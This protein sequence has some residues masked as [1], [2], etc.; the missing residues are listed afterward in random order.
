MAALAFADVP[1]NTDDTKSVSDA[2]DVQKDFTVVMAYQKFN[3]N[4]HIASYSSDAQILES[5]YEGVFSYDPKTL[6]PVPALAEKY[7]ISRDKLRWTLTIRDNA[8]FSTGEKITAAR[9]RQSWLELLKTPGAPYAS[10]L[11]CVKN[12]SEFR[13]G[14]CKDADVGL[15]ARNDKTLVINLVAPT[16][17]LARLLCHHA[18]AVTGQKPNSFSGAYTLTVQEEEKLVL[19][20]NKNYWDAK[21]VHIPTITILCSSEI[22]ENSWKFNTGAADWISTMVDAK[23]VLNKNSIH[24]SAVFGTEYIF[25]SCNKGPCTDVDFRNA[26]VAAVPWDKLRAGILIPAT[27]FIYP[28][29]G[30]PFV[31]GLSDTSLD[32]A[33][34]MMDAARAK[35]K[36][37][38]GQKIQLTFGISSSSDRQKMFVET[39]KAA[40]APLGVELS[41]SVTT[42]ERYISSIPSWDADLFTYSWIG[43]FADP[44]AFLELFRDGSTLNVSKWKNEKYTDLLNKAAEETDGQIHYKLLS[45]AE[46]LL[47]DEGEVL[48]V[49]HSVSLHAINLGLVGGWYANPLDIHP[50]KYLYFKK[51]PP[52]PVYNVVLAK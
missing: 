32:D 3:L 36:I 21:N 25:F 12:A 42:D 19:A 2:A 6:E 28:L 22:E 13:N 34:E 41:P 37:P 17:H 48:P 14:K 35:L 23:L 29:N 52:L 15:V 4:P 7:K 51:N 16:A 49:G 26:L 27:N 31:E 10:L 45:Q 47:L 5:L 33:K 8:K 9:I 43:D 46:Q 18:F 40:W 38:K 20:K 24:I 39:L 44:L 50:Y 30:Y 11:D 1:K